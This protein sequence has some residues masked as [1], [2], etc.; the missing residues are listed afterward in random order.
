MYIFVMPR[1]LMFR[2][3]NK[4]YNFY[5]CLN[6]IGG[7]GGIYEG[8]CQ[9]VRGLRFGVVFCHGLRALGLMGGQV[10]SNH[11]IPNP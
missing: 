1:A 7:P 9:Q 4:V 2:V 11:H 10:D 8:W 3:I 5:T 6:F